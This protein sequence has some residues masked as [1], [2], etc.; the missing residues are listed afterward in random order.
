MSETKNT[1]TGVTLIGRRFKFRA[2]LGPGQV[3][4]KFKIRPSILTDGKTR[5]MGQIFD[6]GEFST[7]V[8]TV[9]DR[10][11]GRDLSAIRPDLTLERMGMVLAM[12]L[13][14]AL[15]P[16]LLLFSL[17]LDHGPARITVIPS[18]GECSCTNEG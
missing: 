5:T 17:E 2:S 4:S 8:Y 9:L 13:Q 7:V 15:P 18:L 3:P 1:F 11:K 10:W 14:A 6:P 16:G 12:E